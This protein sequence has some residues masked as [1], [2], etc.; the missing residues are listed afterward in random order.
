MRD[1]M[2]QR[3]MKSILAVLLFVLCAA[4]C[5]TLWKP[6]HQIPA[7]VVRYIRDNGLEY[8]APRGSVERFWVESY[9]SEGFP[10]LWSVIADF[11]GDKKRDF[12]GL[13]RKASGPLDLVVVYSTSSGLVHK[14]LRQDASMDIDSR[15]P[16]VILEPPG[17]VEGHPSD[18]VPNGVAN[19]K[20]QG[21]HLIYFEKSSVLFYW[22]NDQFKEMW[23]SD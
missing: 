13:L 20:Y 17:R 14:V 10:G 9:A 15:L 18:D 8:E 23:T 1:V 21:I 3:P 4:S 22:E 2:C 12:A 6:R 7:S 16:G 11:N 19:L 5:A